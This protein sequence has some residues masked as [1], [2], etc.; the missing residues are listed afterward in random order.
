MA[1][2]MQ[3]RRGTASQWTTAN[4]VLNAGEMG[5]ESD[6][7]K[8]KIGDGTTAWSSLTYFADVDELGT[9]L[10]GDYVELGDIGA[11]NGVVGLNGS[12]NAIVPGASIIIEGS[13]ANEFET[14]L[15]VTDPTA[16]RT[17]TFPDTTGTVVLDT[18]L[19]EMAQ[20]AVNTALVAGTGLD[21]TYNDG[22]NTIT[23]DIDS[24]VTT[25]SGTQ[26]LTNKTIALGSNSISGT[27]AEFNSALSDGDFATTSGTSTLTNKTISLTNNT[28]SGT[29]AEFNTAVTDA[30]LASLAGSETLTNKTLGSSTA[31]GADLSAA[32]YKI[33]NLGT[34]T[35]D[36]DAATKSYVDAATAGLNVHAAVQAAT[37]AAV[38][39]ASDLENGDTLDGVTLATGNRVL[40][41]NQADK[42]TNGVY[43]VKA[44][45]APDRA[46]DY[47]TAGEVDAGDFIF[48]EGGTVNGKTG[49]VQ[50]N[51][52]TT[53]GSD[54]VEFTQ[55]SGAGTYSA[56]T[57]LTLTGTTFSINTGTTVDL[58]TAQTLTNKT[59]NLTSNTLTGT[60]EQFN[61]ALSD[62]DF[63]TLAGTETL[64]NKT[65]TSPTVNTPTL[66]L[67][68]STSTTE[69]RIAWD[70]TADK[71]IV[72]DGSTAREFA[73]S[74]MVTNAQT[75]SYTLVLGDKDKMVEMNVAS[76]NNLTVPL[77]SSVAFP[78]GSVINILQ[79]GAGQTTIVAT[80]GVT[81]NNAI[82]LKCRAQWSAVTLIK[83]ATDTW[84]LVGD[85]AA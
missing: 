82:G 23:I 4:P 67:S 54:N 63:A 59:V 50:T 70:S 17:I 9:A 66:T 32:T 8:F 69:G 19:D 33:T 18:T 83:R 24:T 16:D 25:N 68:T 60:T 64:T 15:T 51:A 6:T 84:V 65:L 22:A 41:K 11:A 1:T 5:W 30:D 62:G 48:V 36:A 39:L 14:T 47:N 2:R 57:G 31:L 85:T 75:G 21:K 73:S 35:S 7:N 45:G 56:G 10:T 76:A 37:T 44:S 20:D 78:V 43:V 74:T 12:S 55:F 38:T 71:I 46:D 13:T 72:G 28:V 40:V 58:N 34:P 49:W 80:G 52:I 53:L 77:N 27:T 29:L 79:V 3:Q 61:T 81:I 26:T 42:T